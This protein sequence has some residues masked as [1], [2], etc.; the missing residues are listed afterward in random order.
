MVE[1]NGKYIHER[2]NHHM[3]PIKFLAVLLILATLLSLC[4]CGAAEAPETTGTVSTSPSNPTEPTE[5]TDPTE[6]SDPAQG[7]IT[8]AETITIAQDAGETPTEE[9]YK[10]SG[11]VL[12]VINP[13]YGEMIVEDG[14]GE[15]YIYGSIAPDGTYYDQMAQ[16]PKAGDKIV[17]IGVLMTYNGEPQMGAKDQ[18]AI[19]HHWEHIV[20]EV[21]TEGYT[22][23]TVLEARSADKGAKLKVS[24]IVAAVTY[25]NGKIPCGFILVDST[26]SIY[27]YGDLAMDVS[28]GNKVEVIATKTYWILDSELNNAALHG[29]N[30]ACQLESATLVSNDNGSH[31]FDKSGI[32][33]TT[34]KALLNSG[35]ENNITTQLFKVT[36]LVQKKE[37][38]GFTNYYFY[39]LDGT[40]G[41]YTYTQCNGSDFQWLDAYDG[42]ICTVYLTALNAKSTPAECFYRLLPVA[43]E[44]I[45]DFSYPDGEV[46]AFAIEYSVMDLF[47][48]TYGADPAL[49]LP[50]VYSN[51]LLGVEGVQISYTSSNTAIGKIT[52]TA[53]GAV[54]NLVGNGTCQ[55]TITATYKG[56]T[57]TET[58]TVTSD[59]V[60]K[61]TTPTVAQI[62]A[63]EDGTLVQIR[64][65]VVASLVNRSGFYLGD[66]TGIIA[67]LCDAD[68]LSQ[69]KPG[70]EV[71]MEGYKI[72]F[73]KDNTTSCIGQCAIVG[74]LEKSSDSKLLANYYGGH[75]YN[76]GFAITDKTIDELYVL[77]PMVDYTTNIYKLRAKVVVVSGERYSNIHLM[78]ENGTNMLRLY[79]SNSSS[80]SWLAAYDGQVVEVE[81][82]LCNWN[83][84]SYYT[85]CVLSAVLDG[86]KVINELNFH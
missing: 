75:S 28:V 20:V 11:T 86:V 64:G 65:I 15:L 44:E 74:S 29:Y 67:V 8:I 60:S 30:G 52:T 77:D 46:P 19:I 85:G 78:D 24:G 13:M 5:P 32:Q 66:E 48:S 63:K 73:R 79:C 39:D 80:Y 57:A 10:I 37:G 50:T 76:P 21:D 45:S 71:V 41:S 55:I 83:D 56:H 36:A 51:E 14:T 18:K 40:T 35:F 27:V 62:I 68:V 47:Q 54:L 25:A 42:K 38:T 12:R 26:A 22:D 6:P 69:I 58:V 33:E 61:I 7:A 23:A 53:D 49:K 9:V 17:L 34:V 2:T 84:K 4:A 72:H 81:L 82:A 1:K 16:R 3:K 43:V 59:A 70:D 31:E